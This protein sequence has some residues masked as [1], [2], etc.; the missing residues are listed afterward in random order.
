MKKKILLTGATGYVGGLL[1]ERLI[2][3]GYGVH[4]L[5]RS[6]DKIMKRTGVEV[7]KGDIR[8]ADAVASAMKGCDVAYYLVHG[9]NSHSGFEYE[10]ARSAQVFTAAANEAKLEKI[11]YLGG[12]GEDGELSPHLRSRQLTGRILAL[13]K[14][15]VTEFR[16]SIVLGRGSTSY[17]MMRLLAQRLPFFIDPANLRAHCQP[18]FQEDLFQ[19]LL[20]ELDRESTES[21]IF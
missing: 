8:D 15:P 13:G 6:P 16:A 11:I 17:E 19:Y 18:I 12:L 3:E 7:F 1:L 10:E 9:L 2:S 14:T 21:R 20:R 5:A 4:V